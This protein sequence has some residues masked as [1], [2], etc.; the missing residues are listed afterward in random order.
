MYILYNC[1]YI[2]TDA[3]AYVGVYIHDKC[4]YICIWIYIYIYIHIRMCVCIYIYIFVCTC[5]CGNKQK[6]DMHTT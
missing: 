3:C 6:K 1:I 4:M 2:Y 5:T